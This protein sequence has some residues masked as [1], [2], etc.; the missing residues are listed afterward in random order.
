MGQKLIESISI[1]NGPYNLEEDEVE[2]NV[3]IEDKVCKKKP[4]QIG[5]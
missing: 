5:E 1:S 3:S 4:Q 2:N